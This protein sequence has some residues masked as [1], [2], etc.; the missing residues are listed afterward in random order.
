M[1]YFRDSLEE[2]A[3]SRGATEGKASPARNGKANGKSPQASASAQHS[4]GKVEF[5]I[6]LASQRS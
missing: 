2:Q 5:P 3:T 1:H 6:S 4:N